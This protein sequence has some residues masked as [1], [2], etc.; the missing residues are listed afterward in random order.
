MGVTRVARVTGLDRAGVEVACAVRPGG[1]VLQISNGKGQSW[2]EARASALS[3]AAE[4]WAAERA[5]SE[6]L[7][8]SARELGQ[9]AWLDSA[10]VAA[11]RLFSSAL[12]IA[13]VEA[14]DL[15][16]GA[17]V[18]VPAQAVHCPPRGSPSLGPAPFRWSSNGMGAHPRRPQALLHAVLEAA[19]RGRLTIALPEG[20]NPA[21][22]RKRKIAPATLPARV[23]AICERLG[24]QGVGAG[25]GAGGRGALLGSVGCAAGCRRHPHRSR[26]GARPRDRRIRL[27]DAARRRAPC[28]A[29]R[30]GAVASH[31]RPRR[32][33]RRD[34][35]RSDGGAAS[36]ARLR[37]R[38]GKAGRRANAGGPGRRRRSVAR[39]RLAARR[40][41]RAA[42]PAACLQGAGPGP[43]RVGA[44]VKLVAFLG[45]SLR[46][47][48]ARCTVLPPARK[49]DVWRALTR[50]RPDAIALIDGVFESEPSVWHHEI[51]DAIDAGVAVYGGASMGALR[52]AE[53]HARGMIGVGRIFEW[54]REGRITDDSEVALLH[55]GAEHA[56]RPL[57]VPLVNVRWAAECAQRHKVLRPAQAQALVAAAARIFY[58]DRTWSRVLEA[59]APE[60]RARWEAFEVP[61]LKAEDAHETLRAAARPRARWPAVPRKPAPS[62]LVRRARL[63]PA[64]MERLQGRPAARE[65]SDAGLR[66]A[67]VAGWARECGLEPL[68]AEV[69]AAELSWRKRLRARA[70]AAL[71]RR[72]GLTESEVLRACEEL[73]LERL[74][75]DHAQRMIADGP[76]V[77]E[78][79]AAEARLRGLWD[80]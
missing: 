63:D 6:L 26:G 18:L 34:P 79:L 61:D 72:V 30:G 43:A 54:Y 8:A 16:S 45:P 77:D 51:L 2:E 50:H 80:E 7:F 24:A 33:R 62:S 15:I 53:L 10:E 73:A 12:R 74:A 57:T 17:T 41:G 58:Q 59:L 56:F 32:P 47:A 42:R 19:E 21:A 3:E 14:R 40:R 46:R 64:T 37:S 67:L 71:C 36:P 75:L 23:S 49:G 70:R 39:A 25:G 60:I 76:G 27:R 78:G 28:G 69:R 4:L 68:P 29:A 38:P 9:R 55:A 22:I 48:E 31:R 1:H 52:A 20:W 5:P 35:S 11:P 44:A 13:W 65:L 66:R